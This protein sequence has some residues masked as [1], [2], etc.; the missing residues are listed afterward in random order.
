[1]MP[2]RVLHR[3]RDLVMLIRGRE[4]DADAATYFVK[5]HARSADEIL[6]DFIVPPCF[7]VTLP[8]A[9]RTNKPA[10]F[11]Q[12]PS[13]T[14]NAAPVSSIDQGGGRR[15][16]VGMSHNVPETT[17]GESKCRRRH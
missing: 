4:F 5:A 10:S 8:R 16:L 1:M 12:P 14:T 2:A 9:R 15:R 3:F 17:A 11:C 13:F 7:H 6:R